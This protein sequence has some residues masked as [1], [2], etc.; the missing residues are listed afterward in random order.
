MTLI[1]LGGVVAEPV[2]LADMKAWCRVER[3]DED[4]LI[5]ALTKAARETI[6]GETRLMLVR[7]GFRL[8]VDPVPGDGWIELERHPVD[9][10]T[11]VVA[12]DAAGVPTEFGPGEAV[13]ERALG[14]EAVRVSRRV[15]EAAI[16]GL[17]IEFSAGFAAGEVPEALKL[18]LRRIVATAYEL[19]AVVAIGQQ[20]GL[21]PA[22]ARALIAPF[23]RVR[24]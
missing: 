9:A 3:A 12:Y 21:V 5:G 18:A 14:V 8:I 24:L 20:P 10:V 15:A 2:T 16:N 13:I 4:G 6:E 1:D 17:E 23:R 19:R 22:A 7:R 11:S